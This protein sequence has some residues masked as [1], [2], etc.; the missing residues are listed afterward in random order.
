MRPGPV[1]LS[2][3]LGFFVIGLD[4]SAVNV[5]LP[6]IGHSFG[7]S[8]SALQWIV[9]AYTLMFAALVLSS[10]AISDRIG[11]NRVFG[12][13]LAV[14][15]AASAVGGFAPGLAVLIGARVVQG[16]AAAVMLPSSLALVRQAYP[17]ASERSRA[18]ALWTVGGAVSFAAG[19]IAGGLLTSGLS[20]RAIFFINIPVGALT[21]ALLARAPR[22]PRRAARLDPFGQLAAILALVALTFGVIRGGDTG[23]GTPIVIG[24]LLVSA[25]A[26]AA[27]VAVEAHVADPMVP[28][29]LF[30]SRTVTV[31]VLVGFAVN[32]AFYGMVFVLSLFFQQVMHLS[33]VRAGLMFLPMTGLVAGA[34]VASARA[35]ARFGPKVPIT[36]GQLICVVG[37]LGLTSVDGST[38]WLHIAALLIP[39]GVGLGFAVPSLTAVVLNDIAPERAGMAAGV[40]NSLRQTGGALAVAVFGALVAHRTAFITGMHVSLLIAAIA[41]LATAAAAMTLPGRRAG[42]TS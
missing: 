39:M 18:I 29:E 32:A 12:I 8:T 7:G 20:W 14:F 35:A 13:G 23:F 16:S 1:L 36:V 38:S 30:R 11:A 40:L 19:P 42:V 10:G 31:G 2:A 9:D 5:A 22:S 4:A 27:F 33:A 37:L 26:L 34:N 17:V 6:A 3:L 15:T 24:S 41:V 25:V 28:L 21:L